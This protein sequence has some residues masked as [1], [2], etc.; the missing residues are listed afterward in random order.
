MFWEEWR[1]GVRAHWFDFRVLLFCG[2]P[3][4]IFCLHLTHSEL[5]GALILNH[6][7]AA[8]SAGECKN[9]QMPRPLS[10]RL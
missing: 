6:A 2:P 7:C 4:I 10:Q 8:G 5:L 9:I 1:K 3:F